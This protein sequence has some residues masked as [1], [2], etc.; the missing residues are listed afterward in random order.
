VILRQASSCRWNTELTADKNWVRNDA[1][2]VGF[3][4]DSSIDASYHITG[5]RVSLED[6]NS[7]GTPG[8][9]VYLY[10]LTP[11]G[12]NEGVPLEVSWNPSV[13][14]LQWFA[15]EVEPHGFRPEVKNPPHI[16]TRESKQFGSS[17]KSR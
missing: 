5:Y 10:Y 12:E 16:R 6:R 15:Y 14:R 4:A 2:Y 11:G 8:F 9:T 3:D 13:G 7:D 17:P 1:G